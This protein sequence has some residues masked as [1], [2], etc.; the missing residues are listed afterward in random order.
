MEGFAIAHTARAFGVVCDMFKIVTDSA[1]DRAW[2]WSETV[3]VAASE[4][5]RVVRQMVNRS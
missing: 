3:D 4:I 5:G 1:D 2:S